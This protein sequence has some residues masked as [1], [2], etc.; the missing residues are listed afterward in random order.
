MSSIKKKISGMIGGSM[1]Y[2]GIDWRTRQ[3]SNRP[4]QGGQSPAPRGRGGVQSSRR[5]GSRPGMTAGPG[6]VK[7][8]LSM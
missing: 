3:G 8:P 4:G 5:Q 1:K 7:T 2:T 6:P